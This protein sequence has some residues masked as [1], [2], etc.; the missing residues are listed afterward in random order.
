MP[1][2]AEQLRKIA[3]L[4]RPFSSALDLDAI[5]DHLT[6]VVIAIRPDAACSVRVVDRLAGGYRL[7]ATGG[8]RIGGRRPVIPFGRGLTHVVAE[9]SEP[10]LVAEYPADPRAFEGHWAAEQ[11]L[12][13]YY[14]APIT[15]TGELLAV[16]SVNLPAGAT[17]TAEEREIIAALADQAAVAIRNARLLTKSETRR[18]AAESLAEIGRGLAQTLDPRVLAQRVVDGA[19]E[20]L[21]ARRAILL[22]L[23]SELNEFTTVASSGESLALEAEG[24]ADLAVRGPA[25]RAVQERRPVAVK[26]FLVDPVLALPY[27]SQSLAES[28]TDRA[29]LALPLIVQERVIGVVMVTDRTGRVFDFDNGELALG[30]TYADHA[31][32]A[33]ESARLYSEATNRRREAED[34][35]RVARLLTESLDV[36]TAANRIA[37]TVLALLRVPASVLRLRESDGSLRTIGSAGRTRDAFELG[38]VLPPGVGIAGKA[39]AEG[40]PVIGDPLGVGTLTTDDFRQRQ[41]ASGIRTVL[42]VPLRV[43]DTILGVLAVGDEAARVFSSGE[44]VLLQAFGDQAAIALNNARHFEESERRRRSA[45]SLAELGQLLTRSLDSAE[46]SQRIV[47]SVRSLLGTTGSVLYRVEPETQNLVA[48]T[49]SGDVG[50]DFAQRAAI[51]PAGHG[52]VGRAVRE[53]RPVATA[54][55][56]TDQ[57]FR[58]TPALRSHVEGAA[59]RAFMA[60]PLVVQGRVVGAL[61]VRTRTGHIFDDDEIRL[62]QAF[63]DQAAVAFENSRLYGELQAALSVVEGSRQ[64]TVRTERL[65]AMREVAGGIAH[66]FNNMLAVILGRAEMLLLRA[67]DS[68]LVRGLETIRRVTLQGARTVRQLQEFTGAYVSRVFGTVDLAQVLHDVVELTRQQWETQADARG[69]PYEIRAEVDPVPPVA[70]DA[71]ELREAFTNLLIN[72]LEAMPEG[73][74]FTFRLTREGDRVLVAAQDAGCGVSD[75]MRH[76]IFAPFFTTKGPRRR[77]LGLSAAWGI[78]T[79]HGGTIDVEISP[80]RGSTFLVRLPIAPQAL[81]ERQAAAMLSPKTKTHI[82][83][84]EDEPEVGSLL[85]DLLTAAGYVVIQVNGTAEGLERCAAQ[86]MNLVL[87]EVFMPGMSGWDIAATLRDR[88]PTIPVGFIANSSDEFDPEELRRH[89][90][91]FVLTKPLIIEQVLPSVASVI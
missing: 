10:L 52:G 20:L 25:V 90:I 84:I 71:E 67:Q 68:E 38:Y 61:G 75:V 83:L 69:L 70:G 41:Q 6:A 27:E 23:D 22:L 26:D 18:H 43:A 29:L 17:P 35:A 19:R 59:F 9:T 8:L 47:D 89:G 74:R 44:V 16:L 12:T 55:I 60:V 37:E 24:L 85:S 49:F 13:V 56:L 58:L 28:V 31:A 78:V 46:V 91:R 76:R 63:A 15:A 57:N 11:G 77:G 42:A 14:G 86:P 73:G 36:A 4:A 2:G 80:G 5:L 87:T 72:A 64:T 53:R 48:L 62:A 30:R 40:R 79:R 65:S 39:A 21:R 50:S 82:L 54:D 3:E 34:L 66:D 33:L 45:E 88:F 81:L 1:D 32:L 51:I 7:A